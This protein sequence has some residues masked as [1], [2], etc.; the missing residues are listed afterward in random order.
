M[1]ETFADHPVVRMPAISR[2]GKFEGQG[3]G[4]GI[5]DRP[6]RQT[7]IK[8][9]CRIQICI[10]AVPTEARGDPGRYLFLHTE[11]SK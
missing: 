10:K 5:V 7:F 11:H 1:Y 2:E 6:F 8:A 9:F 3:R 4:T